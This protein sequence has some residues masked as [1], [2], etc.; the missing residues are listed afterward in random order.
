MNHK[1][2]NEEEDVDKEPDYLFLVKKNRAA[3]LISQLVELNLKV[4]EFAS[5]MNPDHTILVIYFSNEVLDQMAEI[6][7]VKC[8][9]LDY[10]ESLNFK[11]HAEELYEQFQARQKQF[12]M[13]QV[14]EQEIDIDYYNKVGIII[15]HFPLHDEFRK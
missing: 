7:D 5:A 12:L 6:S 9:L 1:K 14:F 11:N 3:F 10:N 2:I 15:D 8:R 13:Q 4:K